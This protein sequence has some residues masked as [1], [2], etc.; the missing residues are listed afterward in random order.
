MTTTH[1]SIGRASPGR[2]VSRRQLLLATG[3]TLGAGRVQA[4]TAL[5]LRFAHGAAEDNPRHQAALL[6]ARR[7]EQATADRIKVTV[8]PASQLG[9]DTATLQAVLQGRIDITANSQGTAAGTVPEYAA[10]G[11]P[12]VFQTQQQVWRVLAGPVGDELRRRSEAKGLRVL[13]FWD[14]GFRHITNNKRPIRRPADL[15]GL[16]IR[17]P[18]DPVTVAMMRALGAEPVVVPFSEL[19]KALADGR[20]DGQENPLVNIYTAK[21]QTMQSH[22]ALSNH[23]V[24]LTPLVMAASTWGRLSASD[25]AALRA[26]AV[27]ATFH[28]RQA[29]L[30]AEERCLSRLAAAGM[31]VTPVDVAAFGK[32]T[33]P[34]IDEW[35][36]GPLGAFTQALVAAASV[37]R[38]G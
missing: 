38:L 8:F 12:Y 22:L 28:Q 6:F 20:V 24:E 33:T 10:I 3:A 36:Q 9:D 5:E 4:Q 37:A 11:L 35:R 18:S 32:A 17:T 15:A 26:A 29:M 27:D 16:K 30:K 34:L 25:Q 13:G 14:N 19:P 7:V 31:Q 23:K 2:H 1:E 21:L